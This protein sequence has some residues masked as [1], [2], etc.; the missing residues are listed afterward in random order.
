M[1]NCRVDVPQR[2][3]FEEMV[4]SEKINPQYITE[5]FNLFIK[6]LITKLKEI[7]LNMW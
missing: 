1:A 6:I 2:Q 4:L 5:D 3:N 7:W